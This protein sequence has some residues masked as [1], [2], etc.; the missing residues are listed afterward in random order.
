VKFWWITSK[1]VDLLE[2]NNVKRFKLLRPDELTFSKRPNAQ[3][4]FT[5]RHLR[6]YL[7]EPRAREIGE[8]LG[9]Y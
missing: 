4:G 9:I 3:V 8:P 1:V 2:R 5:A 7:P 6:H